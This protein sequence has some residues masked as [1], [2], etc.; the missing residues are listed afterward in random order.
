M[1]MKMSYA[2]FELAVDRLLSNSRGRHPLSVYDLPQRE[3]LKA[4]HEGVTAEEFVA[5]QT[6]PPGAPGQSEESPDQ[7]SLF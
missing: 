1:S 2:A 5:A 6:S 3:V 4:Y 7:S